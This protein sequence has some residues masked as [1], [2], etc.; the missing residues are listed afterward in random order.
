L[1]GT[2]LNGTSLNGTSLNGTSLNGTSLNGTTLVGTS[3]KSIASTGKLLKGTDF[4]GAT[5]TGSLANGVPVLLRIDDIV[6]SSDPDI[7]L[8]TVSFQDVTTWKSICGHDAAGAAIRAVPLSGRWDLTSGTATGGDW[9]DE[10]GTLTFACMD[11]AAAK[12]LV[13][14]YKPWASAFE[15]KSGGACQKVS[16]R[17]VH[18]ACTRMIRADYCGDGTSHTVNAVPINL[19][20]AFQIQTQSQVSSTWKSGAEWTPD[21]SVCIDTF[22]YNPNNQASAYV[23]AHCPERKSASFACFGSGSTFFTSAGFSTALEV[24]SLVREEFDQQYV[25]NY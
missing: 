7:L 6:T 9:I 5:M 24:R 23:S 2:S 20:D 18:Q 16:L 13:L 17:P 21:G 12:C 22:R 1:N 8:Y 11:S 19:W 3:L 10:P 4:I 15:C 14:G 25:R